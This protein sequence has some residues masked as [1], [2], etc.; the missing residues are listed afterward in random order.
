MN[1]HSII[2]KKDNTLN[3]DYSTYDDFKNFCLPALI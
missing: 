3:I 1:N 2:K